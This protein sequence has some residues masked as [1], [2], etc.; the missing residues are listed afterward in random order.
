MQFQGAQLAIWLSTC[1]RD[2]VHTVSATR[3]RLQIA[4]YAR[5]NADVARIA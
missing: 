4:G 5:A 2:D 3:E 1:G